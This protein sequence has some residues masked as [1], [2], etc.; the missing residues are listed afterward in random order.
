MPH[1]VCSSDQLIFSM[2]SEISKRHIQIIDF[3]PFIRTL[4]KTQELE[5]QIRNREI[6][7]EY[8]CRVQGEFPR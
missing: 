2:Q 1:N 4:T 6:E 5:S 3:L 7:K 8:V